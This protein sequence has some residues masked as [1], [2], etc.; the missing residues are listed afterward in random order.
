MAKK[1]FNVT[2]NLWRHK[3]LW[4]IVLFI[5]IVGFLDENSF[6]QRYQIHAENERL[7]EEIKNYQDKYA[8]DTKELEELDKSPEAVEKVARL[9]LYMKADKEDVYIIEEDSDTE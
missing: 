9:R 2:R 8:R 6:W 4:T 7:R 3:Y 1:F 5:V